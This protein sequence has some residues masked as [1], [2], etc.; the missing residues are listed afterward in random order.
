MT[1]FAKDGDLTPQVIFAVVG[2]M[3]CSA[4][5]LVSNKIAIYALPAPSFILWGQ[6]FGTAVAVKG[7]QMLGL[8]KCDALQLN[9]V[10]SFAPVALIFL[11]TIFLNMKTLQYANVETFIIFRLSTPLFISIADYVWLGREWPSFRSWISLG[12][13]FLCATAYALTDSSYDVHGYMFVFLW[14]GMFCL[15]Q[16][17]LK[18]VVDSVKME[19]NWGRVFYSNFIAS[20][21]LLFTGW[22]AG[23][24]ETVLGANNGWTPSVALAVGISVL[25]GCAMSYFAWLARSLVSATY[26]TVI[27]NSCKLLTIVI[28]VTIWNK[29]ASPFGIMCLL[30]CLVAAYFYK[31]APVR[32]QLPS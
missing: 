4:L 15:D 31:Q 28:N 12:L 23:E 7:A 21:P 10:I 13:I 17:Y 27:G 14:Y 20:V 30:A 5:M 22:G 6:L 26:F 9:K 24:Y 11:S 8:V 19:S 25:L 16:I 32:Q 18:Y 29:H 1:T 2:Y 3:A